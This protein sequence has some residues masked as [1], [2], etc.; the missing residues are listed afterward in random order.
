MQK[1]VLATNNAG[2]L[3]ELNALL[4]PL[5]LDVLPQNTFTNESADETGLT[6][7]ENAIIK[8]RYAAEISGL[9][10]ISDD[11]GLEVDALKGAPGI[12]S[13]RYA[14]ESASDQDNIDKLLV[15]L[16]AIPEQQRTA[17]FHCVL[18]FMKHALD[19][20]PII[21]HGKWEGLI[22]IE[23]HGRQGFGYDPVFFIPELNKT[24]AQLTKAEKNAI[25]HRGQALHQLVQQL[26]DS[27]LK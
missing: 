7:V 17:R 19:P 4:S 9:P 11:S 14:G 26:K 13:A 5:K 21:C 23:Q 27:F 12:Y 1:I 16:K 15:D 10:A 6:F 3:T 22:T 2:K 8:A 24:S 18:V 20:T 25:S